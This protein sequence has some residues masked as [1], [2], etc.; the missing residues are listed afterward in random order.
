MT[1]IPLLGLLLAGGLVTSCKTSTGPQPSA[2]PGGSVSSMT[3]TSKSFPSDLQ[4]PVDYSCDGKDVSPQ[5]T[6]SAPPQGTKA[7]VVMVDDPDASSGSF[8]HWILLNLP[9]EMLSLA[10]AVDPASIET[11]RQGSPSGAK[12]GQNDFRNVR[13]NGPCP[14]RGDLHRYRFWI[15]AAD[16]VLPLNEG[17][18]RADLDAALSGHLLG[19][20]MLKA[21]FA[22]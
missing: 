9:P 21:T 13:Y 10:E 20:G 2:G 11:A 7:L 12:V 14:P 4:I 19:A 5:L 8:T 16:Q 1:R 3:V 6:W 15:Y 18:T 22:H 17:A